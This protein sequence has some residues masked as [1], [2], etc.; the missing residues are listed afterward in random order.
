MLSDYLQFS[1]TKLETCLC[2]GDKLFD[3]LEKSQIAYK[4]SV[5]WRAAPVV[6]KSR[7]TAQTEMKLVIVLLFAAVGIVASIS[8]Y[9]ILHLQVLVCEI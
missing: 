5:L 8:P 6:H 7:E 3:L 9:Q 2:R 4:R 1:D